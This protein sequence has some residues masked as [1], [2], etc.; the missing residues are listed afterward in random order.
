MR[1][2]SHSACLM[3]F[4][5]RDAAKE[6]NRN[7]D[8]EK[9]KDGGAASLARTALVLALWTF[10]IWLVYPLFT[11]NSAESITQGQYIVRS[12]L[13]IGIMIILFGKTVTDLL[14]PLDISRKKT[15]IYTILLVFYSLALL[16][17]IVFM[18]TRAVG[19]FLNNALSQA[20]SQT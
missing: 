20:A 11:L 12:V 15:I 9:T 13:G 10:T 2:F 3:K 1:L 19:L 7:Q 6:E 4:L 16:A 5:V 18:V 8:M 17:G 14:M